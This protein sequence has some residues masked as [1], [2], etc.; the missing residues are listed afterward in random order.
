M[1]IDNYTTEAALEWLIENKELIESS[2]FDYKTHTF[3]FKV[4]WNE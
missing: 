2:G 1:S 4:Q 3:E